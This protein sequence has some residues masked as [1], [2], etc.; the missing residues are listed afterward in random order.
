[1]RLLYFALAIAVTGCVVKPAPKVVNEDEVVVD[2]D[3]GT[4]DQAQANGVKRGC[5]S[6]EPIAGPDGKLGTEDDS[7]FAER[8]N[9]LDKEFPDFDPGCLVN[10]K[11]CDEFNSCALGL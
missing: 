2:K 3:A 6:D 10:A 11:N 8:C 9:E 7:T 4:C 5:I 1:M